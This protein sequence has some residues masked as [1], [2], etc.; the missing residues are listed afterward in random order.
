MRL[1]CIWNP[2]AVLPTAPHS[3]QKNPQAQEN[4]RII[5]LLPEELTE[6]HTE[7]ER[8]FYD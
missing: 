5:F 3:L 1:P 8:L 6:A 7:K 2:E 4:I